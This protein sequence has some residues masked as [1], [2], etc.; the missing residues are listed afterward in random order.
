MAMISATTVVL[1]TRPSPAAGL[2]QLR[3]AR[4]V[5]LR[6][7]YSKDSKRASLALAP[8]ILKGAPLLAA[9][10]AMSAATLAEVDE[11]MSA[12]R[13]RLSNDLLGWILLVA[14]GLVLSFYTVYSSMPILDDDDDQSSAGGITL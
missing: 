11:R 6:C 12:E 14:V 2:P 9:A 10:S 7:S 13:T 8:V 1:A 3:V 4:A 5:R